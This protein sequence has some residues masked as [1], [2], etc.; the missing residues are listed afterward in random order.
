M[1][2]FRDIR[3]SDEPVTVNRRPM[4]W[5]AAMLALALISMASRGSSETTAARGA[6]E[7]AAQEAPT[8]HPAFASAWRVSITPMDGPSFGGVSTYAADGTI[9]SSVLP[10]MP[11]PPDAPAGVTFASA[12]HGVWEATDAGSADLIIVHLRADENGSF[13]G[14][15]TIR[16]TITL[17][18]D[19]QSF[20]GQFVRT[21]ADPG[22]NTV[23]T[24]EGTVA[25]TRIGLDMGAGGS[26][27]ATPAA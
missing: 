12:G 13:I 21:V 8:S 25:G 14:T 3:K 4:W 17:A 5:L 27:D 22:G 10:V 15:M 6:N 11:T 24:L 9:V 16:A 1:T 2:R 19:G 23:T 26:M 20:V 18:A 7:T